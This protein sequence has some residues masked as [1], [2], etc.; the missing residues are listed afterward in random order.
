MASQDPDT[1]IE[2]WL[3]ALTPEVQKS[4][5]KS[6][7]KFEDFCASFPARSIRYNFVFTTTIM[8][9]LGT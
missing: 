5:R 9:T 1:V 2:D 4:Y 8:I 3:T 6:I 7:K